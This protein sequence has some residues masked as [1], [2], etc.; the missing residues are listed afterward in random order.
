MAVIILRTAI[1]II[2]WLCIIDGHF[3][4]LRYWQ[5]VDEPPGFFAVIAFIKSAIRTE[6][7]VIRII[8][9]KS[10]GM[11]INMFMFIVQ[12]TPYFTAILRDLRGV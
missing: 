7:N 3:I 6:Q 12:P 2:K 5:I 8:R 10:D 9:A 4:E 1:N 11:I